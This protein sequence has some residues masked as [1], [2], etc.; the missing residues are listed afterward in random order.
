VADG[1]WTKTD[2]KTLKGFLHSFYVTNRPLDH[3]DDARVLPEI[4]AAIEKHRS[5]II[6]A[7]IRAARTISA[8]RYRQNCQT[9]GNQLAR[10]T[11]YGQP[12]D[13]ITRFIGFAREEEKAEKRLEKLLHRV[14][15]EPLPA[16]VVSYD[17]IAALP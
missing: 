9:I 8:E 4:R 5:E 10:F 2:I 13:L 7:G 14:L 12:D 6:L 1:K 16:E 17:P 11:E 15:D 3:R